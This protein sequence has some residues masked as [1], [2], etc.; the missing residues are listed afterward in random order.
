[1]NFEGKHLEG[2]LSLS[3]SKSRQY[4]YW[5]NVAASNNGCYEYEELV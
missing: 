5:T 4:S 1:M 2:K 3:K